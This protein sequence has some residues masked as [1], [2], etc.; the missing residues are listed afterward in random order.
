M[1]CGQLFVDMTSCLGPG[2]CLRFPIV[3]CAHGRFL[4]ANLRSFLGGS[5]SVTILDNVSGVSVEGDLVPKDKAQCQL[6]T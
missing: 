1:S 6:E 2:C 3:G 4:A 5:F